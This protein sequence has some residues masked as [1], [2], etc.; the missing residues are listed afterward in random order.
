MN[1]PQKNAESAKREAPE[2]LVRA[3]GPQ[4]EVDVASRTLKR[5][6]FM[7]R[8]IASDGLIVMPEGINTKFF[9]ANPVVLAIHGRMQDFPVCGRSLGLRPTAGGMESVTQFAD[10]EL[11]RE[12][13]YLYGVN[14]KK[15]V[16]ARGW[17][18]AW[19]TTGFEE[20]TL[21]RAQK[22]L[23]ADWDPALVPP[24]VQREDRVGVVTACVMNEYSA[25]PLGADKKAL[26]RAFADA[27]NRTAGAWLADLDLSE[28]AEKIRRLESEQET[29]KSKLGRLEEDIQAL[30][31]DGASAAARGDSDAILEEL[32]GMLAI[33]RTR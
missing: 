30:R 27:G 23:G 31:R 33:L 1:Q 7:T 16:Y 21:A 14:D 15:E 13:A 32:D 2:R 3:M 9:E 11:G 4:V 26:S 8:G 10:T 24:W 20:W 28:A 22:W 5:A 17:S 6:V 18:F 12:L 25:V 29:T 19:S